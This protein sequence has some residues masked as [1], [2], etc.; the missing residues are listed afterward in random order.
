[1]STRQGGLAF[2][3]VA[4]AGAVGAATWFI[5]TDAARFLTYSADVY[6][7]YWAAGRWMQLHVCA[8]ICAVLA[9]AVQTTLGLVGRTSG[10]HRWCGRIYAVSVAV[11]CLGSL[12]VLAHGSAVG[13]GFAALVAVLAIYTLLFT[14]LG[15]I[16][17]LRR[18]RAAHREWMIRSY[19][20]V[21]VF[22]FFRAAV[23]TSLLHELPFAERFTALMGLTMS[24]A[25]VAAELLIQLGLRPR[26]RPGGRGPTA[27]ESLGQA[28]V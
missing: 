24:S 11:S 22:G 28:A 8:G 26:T 5:L 27:A 15:V 6:G 18:D 9:G 1:M 21:L 4:L 13:P 12:V 25:L 10:A 17:I 7:P 20:A 2:V 19:M 3:Y 14:A 23:E 16:A